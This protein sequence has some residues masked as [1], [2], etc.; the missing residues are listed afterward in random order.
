[1]RITRERSS[2]HQFIL[3]LHVMH[4]AAIIYISIG[5]V[6][7]S[8]ELVNT[9][10]P[11]HTNTFQD[12]AQKNTLNSNPLLDICENINM[13]KIEDIIKHAD[14][15][16]EESIKKY[17]EDA[18]IKCTENPKKNPTPTERITNMEYLIKMLCKHS[19]TFNDITGMILDEYA[20]SWLKYNDDNG[21]NDDDEVLYSVFEN[22]IRMFAK[23]K[24]ISAPN[25]KNSNI[26]NNTQELLTN[27]SNKFNDMPILS[28]KVYELYPVVK[29]IIKDFYKIEGRIQCDDPNEE[30][31]KFKK[32]AV[33]NE[34]IA[35]NLF[36]MIIRSPELYRK[37]DFGDILMYKDSK[38]YINKKIDYSKPDTIPQAFKSLD[39]AINLTQIEL[40]KFI[41]MIFY[42]IVEFRMGLSKFNITDK[43]V[44]AIV[45]TQ[46]YKMHILDDIKHSAELI[47]NQ[48]MLGWKLTNSFF[49]EQLPGVFKFIE[50]VSNIKTSHGLKELKS[51]LQKYKN[52]NAAEK[53]QYFQEKY[54]EIDEIKRI[55]NSVNS[56]NMNFD[57]V[58]WAS[59]AIS[60]LIEEVLKLLNL[61]SISFKGRLKDMQSYT[62][63][64][65][66]TNFKLYSLEKD[67]DELYHEKLDIE[68]YVDYIRKITNFAVQHIGLTEEPAKV[69]V[70]FSEQ[71]LGKK[72]P[73]D[74]SFATSVGRIT[75]NIIL[76]ISAASTYI[77]QKIWNI[78]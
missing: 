61:I 27:S 43:E 29:N 35:S 54:L 60:D 7:A 75:S 13:Y 50:N 18:D 26:E 73:A 47:K 72:I 20:D 17:G 9:S 69:I 32:C 12:M 2:K 31:G 11:V 25:T 19:S 41:A 6:H 57:N 56:T 59:S 36:V 63:L 58:N 39:A 49:I 28:Y 67:N 68:E 77:L 14:S 62:T 66:A 78:S 33:L 74:S 44:N 38:E 65:N 34:I 16:L 52:R 55:I 30:I 51:Y 3:A 46:H 10:A 15:V 21:D 4:I 70:D 23:L 37:Y 48:L 5:V 42:Q 64:T 22:T 53:N 1:M 24:V 8:A 76:A 45:L 40:T 71:Y